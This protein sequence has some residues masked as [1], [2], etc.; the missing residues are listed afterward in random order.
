MQCHLRLIIPTPFSIE[1]ANRTGS[2]LCIFRLPPLDYKLANTVSRDVT[3]FAYVKRATLSPFW[4]TEQHWWQV[5]TA[6]WMS[7]FL[8]ASRSLY[9]SL[10][11]LLL[12]SLSH[13][14]PLSPPHI[15]LSLPLF[16]S[17]FL[18][19]SLYVSI[20]LSPSFS[21][22]LSRVEMIPPYTEAAKL[23][24]CA[25]RPKRTPSPTWN[26]IQQWNNPTFVFT[27]EYHF[28]HNAFSRTTIHMPFNP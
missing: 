3:L 21:P 13:P 6:E 23:F 1:R 15:S 14:S 20:F 19:F 17:L 2:F 26:S 11:L 27:S 28:T 25:Q 16:S 10:Y 18:S 5:V 22:S 7:V 8:H 12:L 4:S 24:R 9:I